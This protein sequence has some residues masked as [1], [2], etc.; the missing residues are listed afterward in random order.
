MRL[1]Q[2]QGHKETVKIEKSILTDSPTPAIQFTPVLLNFSFFPVV[3]LIFAVYPNKSRLG[4]L[5][6]VSA[7]R[8][9]RSDGLIILS[10]ESGVEAGESDSA[11]HGRPPP[12]GSAITAASRGS[13][14]P[15]AR[16]LSPRAFGSE[17][18]I[19]AK[20]QQTQR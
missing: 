16:R 4:T 14:S 18:L 10:E 1:G 9:S 11:F 20:Q 5:P 2:N 7:V 3:F 6:S 17:G 13:S 15:I 8:S 19:L 12:S